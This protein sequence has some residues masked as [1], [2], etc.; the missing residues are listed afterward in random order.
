MRST[1]NATWVRWTLIVVLLLF[2]GITLFLS[3]SVLF[4]LFGMREKEGNYV[5]FVVLANFFA[6]VLYF[7]AAVGL[8]AHEPWAR[9][10]LWMASV[11]LLLA[12][13]AFGWYVYQGGIHEQRTIGAMI[14]RTLL[15]IAFYATA[16]WIGRA[17][18]Q[19][20]ETFT[21]NTST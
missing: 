5:Q 4:D 15:T 20:T 16:V 3:T 2:G 1:R 21:T 19:Q 17:Q 11:V 9:H 13:L 8:I 18:Q 6:S 10:P 12:S 7:A 14:F